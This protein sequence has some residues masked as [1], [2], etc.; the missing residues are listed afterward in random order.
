MEKIK[1]FE[2]KYNDFNIYVK[3]YEKLELG[4]RII[5]KKYKVLEEYKTT[6]RNYV[7]K[8]KIDDKMYILKSPK[9]ETVIPQRKIQTLFKNGE[10]LNSFINIANWQRQGVEYFVEPLIAI[11]KRSIFIKESYLLMEYYENKGIRTKKDIDEIIEI[12]KKLHKKGIYHG[13]LNT[14][15]FLKTKGGIKIIDTQAKNEKIWWFKRAYDIL[16]LKNDLLVIECGYNVDDNYRVPRGVGYLAAYVLKNI[17]KLPI[18]K[19]IREI[20]AK[21][22]EKGVKI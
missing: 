8:I 20:K 22:R 3:E 18:V 2:E 12:I 14:S 13:D 9:S 5:E 1:I 16:T 21:L 11:V 15:N 6:S 17:K 19:K 10:A 7:A 4:K